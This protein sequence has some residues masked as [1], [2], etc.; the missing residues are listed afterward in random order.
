MST[1]IGA[2]NSV[3]SSYS[4]VVYSQVINIDRCWQFCVNFDKNVE[5]CWQFCAGDLMIIL[6][7]L[8]N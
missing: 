8:V 7:V 4:N 5:G 2:V 6:C 1:F 3:A